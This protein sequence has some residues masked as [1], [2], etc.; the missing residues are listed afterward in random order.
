MPDE[1]NYGQVWTETD[2]A[3]NKDSH[4]SGLLPILPTTWARICLTMQV[5]GVDCRQDTEDEKCGEVC[6]LM[7]PHGVFLTQNR[8]ISSILLTG[9]SLPSLGQTQC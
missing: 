7:D 1:G 2:V 3:K 5:H 6:L 8:E 9:M 4:Y